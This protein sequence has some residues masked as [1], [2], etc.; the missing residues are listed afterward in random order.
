[1]PCHAL[2]IHQRDTAIPVNVLRATSFSS[3]NRLTGRKFYGSNI[4]KRLD[5][6][7]GI[8][9]DYVQ[10]QIEFEDA[11]DSENEFFF[12]FWFTISLKIQRHF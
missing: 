3:S 9:F 11:Q 12:F 4:F 8:K 1:M 10:I 5:N 7:D 2:T 6:G